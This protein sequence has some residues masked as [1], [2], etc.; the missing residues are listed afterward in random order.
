V[1][2][3]IA[4]WDS[5]RPIRFAERTLANTA[6]F[7]NFVEFSNAGGCWSMLGMQG[8]GMQTLSLGTGCSTGNA[9]HEIGHAVSLW[10]EQSREERNTFVTITRANIETGMES[11]FDQHIVDGDDVG[12]NDYGSIMHYQRTTFSKNRLETITPVQAGAQLGQRTA[13]SAGDIAA[14]NFMYP[15]TPRASSGPVVSWGP[16]RL[17]AFVLGTNRAVFHK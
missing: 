14:V 4:H 15:Q 5:R 17:D 6:Q 2:D 7:P 16:N 12:S 11:Q 8:N 9:I 3:A 1:R 10:H 13:L